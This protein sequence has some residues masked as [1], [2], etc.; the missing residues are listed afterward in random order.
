M[1]GKIGTE[2]SETGTME[3]SRIRRFFGRWIRPRQPGS[4]PQSEE[5]T[6]KIDIIRRKQK[7]AQRNADLIILTR[8]ITNSLSEGAS[9]DDTTKMSQHRERLASLIKDEKAQLDDMEAS[10][11]RDRINQYLESIERNLSS[12]QS[13]I[14]TKADI[15]DQ[16]K[17]LAVNIADLRRLGITIANTR[18]KEGFDEELSRMEQLRERL[19]T[20]ITDKRKELKEAKTALRS[21]GIIERLEGIDDDS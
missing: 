12:D 20:F 9:S 18:Q 1:S 21:Q 13:R 7:L 14:E 16:K 5:A 17:R 4:Q 2:P 10:M 11:E 15:I 8:E 3:Q 6:K 19:A